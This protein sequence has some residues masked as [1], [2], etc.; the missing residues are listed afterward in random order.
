MSMPAYPAFAAY[1]AYFFNGSQIN[2]YGYSTSYYGITTLM[3][4]TRYSSSL[5][6]FSYMSTNHR[7][8]SYSWIGNRVWVVGGYNPPGK[9]REIKSNNFARNPLDFGTRHCNFFEM[10]WKHSYYRTTSVFHRFEWPKIKCEWPKSGSRPTY[11][12]TLI[13]A[14][15]AL[16]LGV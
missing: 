2:I 9:L 12:E 16:V 7:S 15:E 10:F 5:F 11:L 14:M 13:Y 8:G 4:T 3:L 1:F 6:D